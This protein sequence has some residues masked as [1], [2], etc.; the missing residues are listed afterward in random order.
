MCKDCK[1]D[2]THEGYDLTIKNFAFFRSISVMNDLFYCIADT[3]LNLHPF[4]SS[5]NFMSDFHPVP[6]HASESDLT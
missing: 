3:I 4:P 2:R 1:V 6:R 5:L